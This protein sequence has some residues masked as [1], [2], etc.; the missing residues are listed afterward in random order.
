MVVCAIEW[1]ALHK[2]HPIDECCRSN[3]N[4]TADGAHGT[5][6]HSS[7]RISYIARTQRWYMVALSITAHKMSNPKKIIQPV[8]A[9]MYAVHYKGLVSS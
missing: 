6:S 1:P 7:I 3:S 5:K 9:R 2:V 4:S 8:S